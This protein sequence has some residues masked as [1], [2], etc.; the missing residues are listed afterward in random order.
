MREPENE[1]G[2][3]ESKSIGMSLVNAIT[4]EEDA[5]FELYGYYK[6]WWECEGIWSTYYYTKALV[7]RA[8]KDYIKHSN[9]GPSPKNNSV[10]NQTDIVTKLLDIPCTF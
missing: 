10:I 2:W 7:E 6:I 3:D 5:Q 1:A 9:K 8:V 4:V